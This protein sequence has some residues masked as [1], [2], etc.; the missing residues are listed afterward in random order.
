MVGNKVHIGREY[1]AIDVAD[2]AGTVLLIVLGKGKRGLSQGKIGIERFPDIFPVI[3]I[4]RRFEIEHPNSKL[5]SAGG[6]SQIERSS[7]A[8]DV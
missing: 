3:G 8:M 7:P 1:Q 2:V 4:R 5:L 6:H